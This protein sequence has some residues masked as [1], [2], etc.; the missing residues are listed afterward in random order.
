MT[1][2]AVPAIVWGGLL[3]VLALAV[4]AGALSLTRHQSAATVLETPGD[5]GT[6]P[7]FALTE[8]SG[9]TLTRADLEGSYWVADFIFTRCRGICPLLTARMAGLAKRLPDDVRLVSF[10]V[11]PAH[12]TPE[13]LRHYADG[14]SARGADPDRWLFVTGER[15]ALHDLIS[16]GFRLNVAER[17][18]G[19]AAADGELITH[20]DRFVLVGPRGRIRGYYHGTEEESA[21]RLARDIARLRD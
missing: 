10:S 5:Y 15:D 8:R 6:V 19:D 3:A 16:D 13:V 17:P 11:D 20:S 9:R 14:V 2:R 21:A 4:G 1:G 7:D 12:D 18:E